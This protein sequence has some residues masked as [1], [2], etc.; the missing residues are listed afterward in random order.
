MTS[1]SSSSSS[2]SSLRVAVLLVGATATRGGILGCGRG[3]GPA[4]RPEACVAV[5]GAAGGTAAAAAS[6]AQE[7]GFSVTGGS[8]ATD[9]VSMPSNA[10][11]VIVQEFS[12]LSVAAKSSSS[13]Q[14]SSP[15][16]CSTAKSS[17]EDATDETSHTAFLLAAFS[18]RS[19]G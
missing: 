3:R 12:R 14:Y 2:S 13:S 4:T 1:S 11:G 8:E 5:D 17:H 18:M 15:N 16:F 19:S 6:A 9:H 7:R 10:S